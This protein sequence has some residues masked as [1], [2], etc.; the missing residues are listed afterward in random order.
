MKRVFTSYRNGVGAEIDQ[1]A[2]R[3]VDSVLDRLPIVSGARAATRTAARKASRDITTSVM[4]GA[5]VEAVR[6]ATSGN[7]RGI[8][9]LSYRPTAANYESSNLV[10]HLNGTNR[11]ARDGFSSYDQWQRSSVETLYGAINPRTKGSVFSEHAANEFIVS[12]F[13]LNGQGVVGLTGTASMAR[14]NELVEQQLGE[15]LGSWG[16]LLREDMQLR[17]YTSPTGEIR[18]S[19]VN[20]YIKEVGT[21]GTSSRLISLSAPQRRQIAGETTR[22][23]RTAIRGSADMT[24][25]ARSM[26]RAVVSQYDSY[27][28]DVAQGMQRNAVASD[29]PFGDGITGLARY[30]TRTRNQPTQ[31]MSRDHADLILRYHYHTKVMDLRNPFTIG[32]N[33]ARR[34]AQQLTR[35]PDLPDVDTAYRVLKEN[36]FQRLARTGPTTGYAPGQTGRNRPKTAPSPAAQEPLINS[37]RK[38]AS[39]ETLNKLKTVE[40]LIPYS[41][42]PDEPHRARLWAERMLKERK[43]RGDSLSPRVRSFLETQRRLDLVDQRLGKPCGRSFIPKGH[44]CGQST[45]GTPTG[46]TKPAS[47]KSSAPASTTDKPPEGGQHQNLKNGAKVVG[48]VLGAAAAVTALTV[49]TDATRYYRNKFLPSTGN[50]KTILKQ[51]LKATGRSVK[52]SGVAMANYY[53]KVAKDWRKGEIVYYKH[54]KDP[55]GH[56][57]I[58]LGKND[59]KHQFAGVGAEKQGGTMTGSVGISE[60]GLNPK[61]DSKPVVWA[62][63]PDKVQPPRSYS[64]TEIVRRA[65]LMLGKPFSF[66][67]LENNCEGW[68]CMIVSGVPYSTQAQRFSGVSKA[69]INLATR[70]VP[71]TG[72]TAEQM[73]T[74]LAFNHRRL[75]KDA[76]DFETASSP[77]RDGA[78]E[79]EAMSGVKQALMEILG[80]AQPPKDRSD[81]QPTDPSLGKPCGR[82]FI[83]KGHKCGHN[84]NSVGSTV[85]KAAL[86]TGVIAAAAYSGKKLAVLKDYHSLSNYRGANY[87]LPRQSFVKRTYKGTSS[88]QLQAIVGKIKGKP[89][90]IDA[91]VERLSSFISKHNVNIT[92]DLVE[93]LRKRV[94]TSNP[95]QARK[96]MAVL[97]QVD[98]AIDKGLVG[99]MASSA[100]RS[101][102]Y[103]RPLRKDFNTWDTE[104]AA[105]GAVKGANKFMDDFLDVT[106][107]Q[108]NMQHYT[109]GKYSPEGASSELTAAIHEIGHLIDYEASRNPIKAPLPIPASK[110][111]EAL[112]RSASLYGK[113]DLDKDQAE[114]FAEHFALYIFAGERLKREHPISYLWVDAK[115]KTAMNTK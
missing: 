108:T 78:T 60:Y 31:I 89:G 75:V 94:P 74:W 22:L 4:R 109:V 3:A 8:G 46:K 73:Q 107:M 61:Y 17:R 102:I 48:I 13:G 18:S 29:S 54:P 41:P 92:P 87:K 114:T 105:S 53:D 90:V 24:A 37:K 35:N 111:K 68:A 98:A 69:L 23:M 93:V 96:R 47:Q 2:A 86:A 82:S 64:D 112:N 20:R 51:E 79:L 45:A 62:K 56:F 33:T 26:R 58:Y 19:D 83:P 9:P 66:D 81:F 25:E 40:E 12:K 6:Q 72:Y 67:I 76:A 42:F 85:A 99:G 38:F 84:T 104:S 103:V 43:N 14:R 28:A 101:A 88:A 106:R 100:E 115:V 7:T 65:K 91:D 97:D 70:N 44:K 36:G 5:R 50:Y 15:R 30:I 63:A 21:M 59:G 77:I 110:I 11:Q 1:A 16:K 27:F 34:V 113:T 57:G 49:A 52:E 10:N 80:G 95:V 71:K 39:N 32:D 55:Q